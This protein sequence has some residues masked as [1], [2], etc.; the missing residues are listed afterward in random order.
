MKWGPGGGHVSEVWWMGGY[1]VA[2]ALDAL[3]A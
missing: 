1:L 2:A 3:C